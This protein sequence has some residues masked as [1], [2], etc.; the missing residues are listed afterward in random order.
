MHVAKADPASKMDYLR[1]S[2]RSHRDY[3]L[4][5]SRLFDG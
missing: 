3:G 2:I 5:V 4:A 1:R